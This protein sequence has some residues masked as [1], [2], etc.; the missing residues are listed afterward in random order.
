MKTCWKR[1]CS[2]P[3]VLR[4]EN[5][6]PV[7]PGLG[8]T[9]RVITIGSDCVFFFEVP[10][11]VSKD[12]RLTMVIDARAE[13][14]SVADKSTKRVPVVFSTRAGTSVWPV[15]LIM[16]N[17][18]RRGGPLFGGIFGDLCNHVSST[19]CW[20]ESDTTSG[21]AIVSKSASCARWN[22]FLIVP[23]VDLELLTVR[24]CSAHGQT[25]SSSRT[26]D[27]PTAHDDKLYPTNSAF[28]RIPF[29]S[30]PA[31]S[32]LPFSFFASIPRYSGLRVK[33]IRWLQLNG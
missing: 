1:S 10:S 33:F 25:W 29:P 30:S 15:Q 14:P 16:P 12:Q 18:Q 19:L 13:V 31:L 3:G 28:L 17:G 6:R 20:S 22:D 27:E 23:N 4:W 8:N 32:H 11:K 26:L 5:D 21:V 2:W 7:L 24:I 9:L